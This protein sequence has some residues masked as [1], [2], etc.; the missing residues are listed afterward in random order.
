MEITLNFPIFKK[1]KR[2]KEETLCRESELKLFTQFLWQLGGIQG[3]V[4]RTE[5]NYLFIFLHKNSNFF[6][7]KFEFDKRTT[8]LGFRHYN[9]LDRLWLMDSVLLLLFI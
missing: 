7:L 3:T 4:F 6:Q 1:K 2:K 8:E 9:I 5:S